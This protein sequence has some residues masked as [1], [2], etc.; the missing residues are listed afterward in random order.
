MFRFALLIIFS[1]R[2]ETR[3]RR[4]AKDLIAF[5]FKRIRSPSGKKGIV[6]KLT[7]SISKFPYF[8]QGNG[9]A[10]KLIV[11]Q[12]NLGADLSVRIRGMRVN[13]SRS[14]PIDPR[15]RAVTRGSGENDQSNGIGA[16]S[17]LN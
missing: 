7:W 17:G 4:K 3:K 10:A 16:L 8:D 9:E 5:I 13:P 11:C 1:S 15:D 12:I 6:K 2:K 14:W